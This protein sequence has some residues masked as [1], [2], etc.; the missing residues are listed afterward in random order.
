MTTENLESSGD[1]LVHLNGRFGPSEAHEVGE[2]LGTASTGSHLTLDFT[3]VREFQDLAFGALA[4]AVMHCPATVALRGL[5][6]HQRRM[7]RYLGVGEQPGLPTTAE[8]Q[9]QS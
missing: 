6:M 9:L 3:R 5:A 8:A 4:E 1:I 7:L 2:L